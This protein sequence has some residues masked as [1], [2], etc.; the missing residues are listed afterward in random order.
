[1]NFIRGGRKEARVLV[2]TDG[3]ALLLFRAHIRLPE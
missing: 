1:M 2:I 3:R